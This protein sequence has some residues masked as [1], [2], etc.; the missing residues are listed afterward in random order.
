M[1]KGLCLKHLVKLLSSGNMSVALAI[2]LLDFGLKQSN[3][4]IQ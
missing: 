2:A 1:E 3:T 4:I